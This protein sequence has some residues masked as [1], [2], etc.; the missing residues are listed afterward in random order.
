M[1]TRDL[2]S[3]LIAAHEAVEFFLS[4]VKSAAADT[5][6][7]LTLMDARHLRDLINDLENMASDL[8][9]AAEKIPLL[10]PLQGQMQKVEL[11]K[12]VKAKTRALQ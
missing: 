5:G 12:S 9:V 10:Y 7:K 11:A 4:G 3:R 1:T 2:G 6:F 8:G